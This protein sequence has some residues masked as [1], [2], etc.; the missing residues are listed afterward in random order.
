M[1]LLAGAVVSL[2]VQW[3]K[4]IQERY[5][6]ERTRLLTLASALLLSVMWSLL[7]KELGIITEQHVET[8]LRVWAYSVATYEVLIKN[9]ILLVQRKK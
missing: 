9:V 6:Q 2:L 5:G 4:K 1:E 8:V 7:Y 3:Y